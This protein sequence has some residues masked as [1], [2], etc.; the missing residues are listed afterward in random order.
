[1]VVLA[2]KGRK[3]CGNTPK[4]AGT[5]DAFNE[6]M[7][8]LG[9]ALYGALALATILG[10]SKAAGRP[11]PKFEDTQQKTQSHSHTACV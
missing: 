6:G 1:L 11:L 9:L 2:Q 7:I 3:T 5:P 4:D 8:T 10:L